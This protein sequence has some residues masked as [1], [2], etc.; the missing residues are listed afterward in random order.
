LLN[1]IVI[2]Y[3]NLKLRPVMPNH[4]TGLGAGFYTCYHACTFAFAP[5]AAFPASTCLSPACLLPSAPPC[6]ACLPCSAA[7]LYVEFSHQ[8]WHLGGF[9]NIGGF[10]ERA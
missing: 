2:G 1:F 7:A 3:C 9:N 6:T 5:R 8:A 10:A 4:P